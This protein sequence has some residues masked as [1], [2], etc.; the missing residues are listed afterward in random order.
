MPRAKTTFL[1][2][3]TFLLLAVLNA[4]AQPSRTVAS[5]PKL[6][7]FN[8]T[9]HP[10]NGLPLAPLESV[11][12][13][14]YP[15]QESPAPLWQETQNVTVDSEGRY[16]VVL[17]AQTGDLPIDLFSSSEPRWLGIQFNRP[18]EPEQPRVLLVSVPYALRASDADTLGGRPAWAYA[19]AQPAVQTV[20]AAANLA[21]AQVSQTA[22]SFANNPAVNAA[23]LGLKGNSTATRGATANPAVDPLTY[24]GIDIGAKINAAI[25]ACSGGI[26]CVVSV[27]PSGG[28]YATTIILPLNVML[29]GSGPQ[30]SWLT[31]TGAGTAIAASGNSAQV[32][33]IALQC[34]GNCAYGI[35]ITGTSVIVDSVF[36]TGGTAAST[37]LGI[38]AGN[39]MISKVQISGVPGTMFECHN[40]TN[41]FLTDINAFGVQDNRTSRTFVIDSGCHGTQIENFQSSFS[42]LHGLVVQN[43]LGGPPPH[44]FFARGFIT[45]QSTGGDAW[46]FDSTLGGTYIGFNFV[47]SWAAG[48]G[49]RADGSVATPGANGVHISGGKGISIVA[50]KVRAN[51]A[52]GVLIDNANAGYIHIQDSVIS[53]NNA[54]NTV[55]NGISVTANVDGLVIS[56]NTIGNLSGDVVGYQKYGVSISA[57]NSTNIVISQDNLSNN[58]TGPI[59]NNTP[60]NSYVQSD[61]AGTPLSGIVYQQS[62]VAGTGFAAPAAGTT[63]LTLPDVA[64]NSLRVGDIIDFYASGDASSGTGASAFQFQFVLGAT[65]VTGCSQNTLNSYIGAKSWRIRMR[66]TVRS[67]GVTGTTENME[68]CISPTGAAALTQDMNE[69]PGNVDTTSALTPILRQASS[70]SVG[71]WVNVNQFVL[72]ITRP[73]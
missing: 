72:T 31:Y 1:A 48:A 58:A 22:E 29:Q 57:T 8:G 41:N 55:A 28:V 23:Q 68:E 45:D 12:F 71:S 63:L 19:L 35:D 16:S 50:S 3:P 27:P 32:R 14:V 2:V 26:N 33:N 66:G 17:G 9:F 52:N 44:W 42:G 61:N 25:A 34:S 73:K 40:A 7:G 21:S 15:D 46:L 49:E 39:S 43:T 65:S 51:A 6:V 5:V 59:L 69:A 70:P 62:A 11:T 38:H 18:G 4:Q 36:L 13:A 30:G 37:M 10:A 20:S 54:Q 24:A 67:V 64:P 47:D 53:S 60:A 56:G